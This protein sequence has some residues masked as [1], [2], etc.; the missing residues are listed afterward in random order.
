MNEP[1]REERVNEVIA[2]YLKAVEAGE[3]PDR[4][5]LLRR[6][7]DLEPELR[8]FFADR[9]AVLGETVPPPSAAAPP[10]G[11]VRY[12]GDY[13]LLEEVARGGMGVVYRARQVSLNRV[14]ALK[15]ILAGQLA[16]EEDV[17]RFHR[18]AEA[19]AS[20]DHPNIVPIYEVGEHEGQHFFSMKLVEGKSLASVLGE[21]PPGPRSRQVLQG[22]VALL[23]KVAQAV[24]H[25]HQRGVLHRDLKPANILIDA[26]GCPFVT[27]FG[28]ARRVSEPGLTQTGAIVGTPSY[29][30]PEQARGEKGVTTAADVHAL[31]AILYEMLVGQPPFRGTTPLDTILQVLDHEPDP[32]RNADPS[33]DP[34]IETI[35]VECLHKEAV[36]RYPSAA[37]VSDELQRWLMEEPIHARRVGLLRSWWQQVTRRPQAILT[38]GLSL[39]PV[40]AWCLW[41]MVNQTTSVRDWMI[42]LAS[43]SATAFLLLVMDRS[44]QT[45][46]S[47][48]TLPI[49]GG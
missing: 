26:D 29:M 30:A 33:I 20:L 15:M 49:P 36:R 38:V 39:T 19:A 40:T 34:E 31:G 11:V 25:A 37:E 13:E 9:D 12:F 41:L 6:H 48:G 17:R 32:P 1:T 8:S 18:E 23:A 22:L 16:S 35:C 10:L 42:F 47:V 14:V 24:H 21:L 27:D 44:R 46:T 5:A 28:L 43:L 4:E 45:G 2:A 7:A 3:R